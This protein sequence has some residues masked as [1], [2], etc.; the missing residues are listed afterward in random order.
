MKDAKQ[1]PAFAQW[2]SEEP[3][4]TEGARCCSWAI[5]AH[6][7][8]SRPPPHSRH[9][10]IPLS[11]AWWRT[12]RVEPPPPPQRFGSSRAVF[13]NS[14]GAQD[15]GRFNTPGSSSRVVHPAP[16]ILQRASA[17]AARK[18]GQA[19]EAWVPAELRGGGN[20]TRLSPV[21]HA[22]PGT[23]AAFQVLG[24]GVSGTSGR[25]PRGG[26]LGALVQ[27]SS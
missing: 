4:T 7:C 20:K 18:E 5:S 13:F 3:A 11:G 10:R 17:G 23:T 12:M 1:G 21:P 27:L 6:P 22:T 9:P 25:G 24:L 2:G 16:H 19:I 15:A 26:T 8:S 14:P